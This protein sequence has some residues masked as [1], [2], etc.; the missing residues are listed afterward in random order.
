[1]RWW[2]YSSAGRKVMSADG[3]KLE[4]SRRSSLE[5]S[6]ASS[7]VLMHRRAVCG[8]LGTAWQKLECCLSYTQATA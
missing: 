5:L 6:Q 7:A 3:L 8:D 4:A 2:R 1:M